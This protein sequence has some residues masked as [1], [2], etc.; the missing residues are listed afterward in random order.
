[1]GKLR[2]FLRSFLFLHYFNITSII[3]FFAIFILITIFFAVDLIYVN[4]KKSIS[5]YSLQIEIILDQDAER[6][7]IK[8]LIHCLVDLQQVE[9]IKF[10]S[11]IQAQSIIAKQLGVEKKLLQNLPKLSPVI[12]INYNFKGAHFDFIKR[13]KEIFNK[14]K[15][16]KKIQY[17]PKAVD[18]YIYINK[19]LN[20]IAL[21]FFYCLAGLL[22]ILIIITINFDKLNYYEEQQILRYVGAGNFFLKLPMVIKSILICMLAEGLSLL[23]INR[24]IAY[25]SSKL[26]IPPFWIHMDCFNLDE[27][28]VPTCGLLLIAFLSSLIS[29]VPKKNFI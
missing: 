12:L 10:F 25:F 24:G 11:S 26:F 9:K 14:K 13:I 16:V 2:I 19:V 22:S 15:I 6:R 4:A 27:L 18:R 29:I 23:L 28:I 5:E 21:P 17:D 7:D 1:M 3:S 8:K 20:Q